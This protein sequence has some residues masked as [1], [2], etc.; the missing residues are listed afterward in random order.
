MD[1]TQVNHLRMTAVHLAAEGGHL[2]LLKWIITKDANNGRNQG[3]GHERL[4]LNYKD[5]EGVQPY[6]GR[7][8]V[9]AIQW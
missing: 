7:A 9:E 8:V 2:E 1:L 5:K 6:I 4:F 3:V